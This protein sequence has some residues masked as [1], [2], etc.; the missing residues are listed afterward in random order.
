MVLA[1]PRHEPKRKEGRTACLVKHLDCKTKNEW[2]G[3]YVGMFVW[4]AICYN[5]AA[6]PL[7]VAK[8]ALCTGFCVLW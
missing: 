6:P 1:H 5:T 3:L 2:S 8:S 4:F 7:Q